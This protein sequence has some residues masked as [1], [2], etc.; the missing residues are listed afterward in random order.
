MIRKGLLLLFGLLC[1]TGL[2]N[3]QND[4]KIDF[5]FSPCKTIWG[6]GPTRI[7]EPEDK[8]NKENHDNPFDTIDLSGLNMER[9]IVISQRDVK[10]EIKRSRVI[11]KT[12]PLMADDSHTHLGLSFISGLSGL[13]CK[14]SFGD[15]S[16]TMSP[17]IGLDYM[18]FFHSRWGATIG[19]NMLW[20]NSTFK[21]NGKFH[22]ENTYV[23]FE[24][25]ELRTTYDIDKIKEKFTTMMLEIPIMASYDYKDWFLSAGLKLGIPF[26]MHHKQTLEGVRI[27]GEYN[28]LP[29]DNIEEALAI[30]AQQIN[31]IE[32]EGKFGNLQTNIMLTG[33]FGHKFRLNDM[34]DFGVSVYTDYSMNSTKMRAKNDV[35]NAQN[36]H[37]EDYVYA[38]VRTSELHSPKDL[39]AKVEHA[40]TLCSKQMITNKRLID[41]F[42]Y[43]NFGLRLT[44]YFSSYGNES[45][46]GKSIIDR[47]AKAR[48]AKKTNKGK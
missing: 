39:P 4:E 3:S 1:G 41:E 15:M 12:A 29:I 26:N 46:E 17:G 8:V 11:R 48:E 36:I 13:Q 33:N 5:D 45:E 6:C 34:F 37:D 43:Y 23:D 7:I 30:G 47:L 42:H 40:S 9:K 10:L 35:K 25:D 20:A 38:L 28:K 14:S 27:T 32:S 2:V 24:G 16:I 22:D 44:L 19:A 18:Y 31:K 21:S